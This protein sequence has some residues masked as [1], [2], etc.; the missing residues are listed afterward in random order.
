MSGA[1]AASILRP[2]DDELAAELTGDSAL[3]RGSGR[4]PAARSGRYV[5]QSVT[6]RDGR[7]PPRSQ[8]IQLVTAAKSTVAAWLGLATGSPSRSTRRRTRSPNRRTARGQA[9]R[10]GRWRS[11]AE[12]APRS[13]DTPAW[14]QATCGH[15]F[16]NEKAPMRYQHACGR[17]S[18]VSDERPAP[19]PRCAAGTGGSRADRRTIRPACRSA[20]RQCPSVHPTAQ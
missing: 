7:T 3:N 14:P 9:P 13:S 17:L 5:A 1:V 16:H 19:R 6:P 8:G 2:A 10:S 15:A 20:R 11:T 18:R 12:S 4:A